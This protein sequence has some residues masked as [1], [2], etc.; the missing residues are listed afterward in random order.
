MI[1]EV[2]D[3]AFWDY[4]IEDLRRATV[5]ERNVIS[6]MLNGKDMKGY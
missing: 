1:K 5:T 3:R 6:Y 4:V 2:N